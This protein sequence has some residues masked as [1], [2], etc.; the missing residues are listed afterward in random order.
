M[1]PLRPTAKIAVA[2]VFA[3]LVC[4][5]AETAKRPMPGPSKSASPSPLIGIGANLKSANGYV[6][7]TYLVPRGPA[8]LDGR[9][10]VGDR[11]MAV[12]AGSREFVD[13]HGMP[14][15]KVVEM[16]RGE[17]GTHVRLLVLSADAREPSQRKEIEL[18]RTEVDF[19]KAAD[20]CQKAAAQGD[21]AAQVFLGELYV[22]GKGVA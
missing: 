22:Q 2:L 17:K 15:D 7:V 6:A 4:L 14:P 9:L 5:H 12:A 3:G 21:V 18:V 16:I 11:I 8:Q 20:L 13:V 1:T 19:S 10:K